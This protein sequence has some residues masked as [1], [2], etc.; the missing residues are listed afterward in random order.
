[1]GRVSQADVDALRATMPDV[2]RDMFAV[3][4]VRRS[5]RCPLPAHDDRTPSA[6][7]YERDHR[8]HCFGCGRTFDV[9]ELVGEAEGIDGFPER[10]RAVADL[11]GYHLGSDPEGATRP[12]AKVRTLPPRPP[13]DAPRPAGAQ[14]VAAMCDRAW[15]QL[16]K[17]GCESGREY[18]RSR[19]LGDDDIARFGLGYCRQPSAVMPQFHVGRLNPGGYVVIPFWDRTFTHANYVMVRTI[20]KHPKLKEIRPK[21]VTSPLWCEWMLTASLPVVYV[22]EGL[23]DAMAL[24]KILDKPVMA[25]GGVGG[26]RRLAQVLYHASPDLRPRRVVVAMDEDEEGRKARDRMCADLARI[27][28]PYAQMPP[29]PGHAK[30]ADEWLCAMRGERWEFERRGSDA[31]AVWVTRWRDGS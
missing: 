2:L 22:T 4:D 1:M 25:L 26:A 3:H 7:Y 16:Y 15:E 31:C 28:V 17:R 5:F 23:I 19:G 11:V 18:L 13:F 10:V 30:D 21:G 12:R 24:T 8:V 27:G 9:F 14:D 6:T 20:A 29:Y